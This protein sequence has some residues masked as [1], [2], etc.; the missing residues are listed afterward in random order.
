MD[1]NENDVLCKMREWEREGKG[2]RV[3]R[4]YLSGYK[5]PDLSVCRLVHA[6]HV[7]KTSVSKTQYQYVQGDEA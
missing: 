2:N 5:R 1:I 7:K 4:Q 6:Y 3:R